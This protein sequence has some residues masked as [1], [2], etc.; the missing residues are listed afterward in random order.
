MCNFNSQAGSTQV[1]KSAT[2]DAELFFAFLFVGFVWLVFVLFCLELLLTFHFCEVNHA[3]PQ[4]SCLHQ[5]S[6]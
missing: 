1:C 4:L 3:Q 5:S 6:P 2:Y